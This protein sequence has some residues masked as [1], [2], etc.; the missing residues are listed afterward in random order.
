MSSKLLSA[1]AVHV[2]WFSHFCALSHS[3]L[4]PGSFVFPQEG[5]VD[6]SLLW[7]DE[8][9]LQNPWFGPHIT[10]RLLKARQ[11]IDEMN[12]YIAVA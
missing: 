5:V 12:I 7:E 1:S 10:M 3:N 8:R 6:H 11:S 2:Y 9:A 4:V